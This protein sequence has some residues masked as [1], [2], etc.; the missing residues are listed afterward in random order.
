MKCK[1]DEELQQETSF[2]TLTTVAQP[3]SPEEKQLTSQQKLD[4]EVKSG[5]RWEKQ[6]WVTELCSSTQLLDCE[7]TPGSW[8]PI[9]KAPFLFCKAKRLMSDNGCKEVSAEVLTQVCV[10]PAAPPFTEDTAVCT[11]KPN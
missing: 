6:P 3:D 10:L 5:P 8:I 11:D 7:K 9:K 2:M 1:L 4:D